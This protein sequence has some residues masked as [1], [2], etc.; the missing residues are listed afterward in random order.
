[1]RSSAPDDGTYVVLPLED[2]LCIT[3]DMHTVYLRITDDL[4]DKLAKL[5][6]EWAFES[7]IKAREM[8]GEV[9]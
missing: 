7:E 1:M 2:H 5:C 4:K 6:S 9:L 8:A 3:G